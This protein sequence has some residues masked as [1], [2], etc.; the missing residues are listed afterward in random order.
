M[1]Q[2]LALLFKTFLQALVNLRHQWWCHWLAKAQIEVLKKKSIEQWFIFQ[3]KED[4]TRPCRDTKFLLPCWKPFHDWAQQ[5]FYNVKSM[6]YNKRCFVLF[7]S[8]TKVWT[9][10]HKLTES[11]LFVSQVATSGWLLKYCKLI[12][13]NW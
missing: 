10:L 12:G 9:W 13:Q 1:R 4:T 6:L 8:K 5:T 2:C 3:S 11:Y 7:M